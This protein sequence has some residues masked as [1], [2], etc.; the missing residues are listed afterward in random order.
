[1]KKADGLL[2]RANALIEV[3][4]DRP[5]DLLTTRTGKRLLTA[6]SL[7][8]HVESKIGFIE[9]EKKVDSGFDF[10]KPLKSFEQRFCDLEKGTVR[11]EQLK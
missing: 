10:S 4:A 11:L 7:L 2:V 3:L 5:I 8:N 6:S 1:M 9:N